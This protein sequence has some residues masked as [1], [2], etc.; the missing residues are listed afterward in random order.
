MLQGNWI[1]EVREY[2]Q[3]LAAVVTGTAAI[4]QNTWSDKK[5]ERLRLLV[6][7]EVTADAVS[8]ATMQKIFVVLD[9]PGVEIHTAPKSVERIAKKAEEA[10]RA[11]AANALKAAGERLEPVNR[12]KTISDLCAV[13]ISCR[14]ADIADIIARIRRNALG[15]VFYV[16]GESPEKPHGD[17]FDANGTLTDIVQYAYL[18]SADIGH[19]VEVRIGEPFAFAAFAANSARRKDPTLPKLFG[20]GGLYSQTKNAILAGTVEAS[21]DTLIALAAAVPE[22]YGSALV[23]EIEK[24]K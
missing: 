23:A 6:T 10:P 2:K 19:I 9:V 21:R 14:A 24:I 8:I 16:R 5:W 7:P 17:S 4:E 18:F 13:R 1:P 12:F 3:A 20:A 15:A 11:E 22:P